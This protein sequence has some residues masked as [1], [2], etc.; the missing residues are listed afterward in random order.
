[1]TTTMAMNGRERSE[2]AHTKT[3]S[4]YFVL[5]ESNSSS[6]RSI[7]RAGEREWKKETTCTYT[8]YDDITDIYLS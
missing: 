5:S 6:S 4:I 2:R 1:M 8:R 3:L 7:S